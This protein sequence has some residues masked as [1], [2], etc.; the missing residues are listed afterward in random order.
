MAKRIYKFTDVFE[1]YLNHIIR[2]CNLTFDDLKDPICI[3]NIGQMV[4]LTI[5][6]LCT[7]SEIFKNRINYTQAV[8]DSLQ[9]R[10]FYKSPIYD[11]VSL[12]NIDKTLQIIDSHPKHAQRSQEWYHFRWERLTASDLGKAVGDRGDKSRLELIYQ[13]SVSL[14]QYIK[15]RDSFQLTGAAIQ[16]GVCFEQV[17]N[18][19]YELKNNVTVIEYGC[20]PHLYIDY[21]AASPDGI[22]KSRETNPNYHG[23]MLEIKCPYSRIINGIPKTEYYMQV[24][25]QLEV[26][27]LEYCDFLECDIRVYTGMTHFLNDSPPGEISYKFTASGNRKGVIYEYYERGSNSMKYKYCSMKLSNNEI[28]KWIQDTKEE[29]NS[30]PKYHSGGCKY[31]W[32]E[33]F[34]ETLI[35]R[36]TEYFNNL[37]T[38]LD[39]FW[40]LVVYHRKNGVEELEYKLGLR[41]KKMSISVESHLEKNL[42]DDKINMNYM[43]FEKQSNDELD[44]INDLDNIDFIDSDPISIVSKKGVDTDTDSEKNKDKTT[45]DKPKE[46]YKPKIEE[47]EFLDI[48]ND[49]NV[50]VDANVNLDGN[51]NT[52]KSISS[53]VKKNI[54]VIKPDSDGEE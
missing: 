44:F 53:P 31:W 50:N 3:K 20:L 38:K 37:K 34:N 10:F 39:D 12:D 6:E 4:E 23:R 11:I 36:D 32:I 27:D 45:K 1:S 22:C 52:K 26:C 48:N 33:E 46:K 30:N 14:D 24:Q 29:I 21:L 43:T 8:K 16:H 19:L 28:S 54:L 40:R 35:K 2:D 7:T 15:Q 25:L 51:S 42:D 18:E 13:K 47:F 41:Q 9:N 49:A 5:K 17:A